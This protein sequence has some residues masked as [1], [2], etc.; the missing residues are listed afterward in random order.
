MPYRELH[1]R[2]TPNEYVERIV[3]WHDRK[4]RFREST[5]DR[6]QRAS[7]THQHSLIHGCLSVQTG[8]RDLDYCYWIRPSSGFVCLR[9]TELRWQRARKR[10]KA[11]LDALKAHHT[12]L[13]AE[14][15]APITWP[16]HHS[17]VSE[18]GITTDLGGY[19]S[20]EEDWD[21]IQRG[22]I[23]LMNRLIAACSPHIQRW[24]SHSPD[25]VS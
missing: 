15:G 11:L 12:D 1:R 17:A 10:H 14:V 19:A 23:D 20:D 9:S 22:M 16:K 7:D 13:E 4:R 2:I 24:S 21:R 6:A 8:H 5:L 18:I 25:D 3:E